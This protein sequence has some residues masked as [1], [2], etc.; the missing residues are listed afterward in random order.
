[1]PVPFPSP[2]PSPS[3]YF[4]ISY[5]VRGIW[6]L[7]D[8]PGRIFFSRSPTLS[9]HRQFVTAPVCSC[10]RCCRGVWLCRLA[11]VFAGIRNLR[12]FSKNSICIIMNR[13]LDPISKEIFKSRESHENLPL[14]SLPPF[15]SAHGIKYTEM[16]ADEKVCPPSSAP[17]R[18]ILNADAAGEHIPSSSG[19][20]ESHQ[21]TSLAISLRFVSPI[22][23]V[24]PPRCWYSLM[25]SIVFLYSV[26]LQVSP[27]RW[28]RGG[29]MV[30]GRWPIRK[31]TSRGRDPR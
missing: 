25:F 19:H 28:L 26:G 14:F 24:V 21:L 9:V 23:S 5:F 3:L 13:F 10:C 20:S 2:F 31:E 16:N 30:P 8:Q 11:S 29:N 18:L 12:A 15:S 4:Y 7:W 27:A 22:V 17:A 1:M 6:Y